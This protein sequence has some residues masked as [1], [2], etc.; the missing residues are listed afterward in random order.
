MTKPDADQDAADLDVA[1][2]DVAEVLDQ[3]VHQPFRGAWSAAAERLSSA[4]IEPLRTG[5]ARHEELTSTLGLDGPAPEEWLDRSERLLEY[6]RSIVSSVL[7]PMIAAFNTEAPPSVIAGALTDAL[8]NSVAACGALPASATFPWRDGAL[9]ARPSDSARRRAGKFLARGVSAARRPGRD[10]SVPLRAVAL[11]HLD[12]EVVNGVDT[13]T[14]AALTAWVEWTRRFEIAWID[15]GDAS[16]SALVK[17]ELPAAEDSD[18]LWETVRDAS[19]GLRTELEALIAEAP[20][21]PTSGLDHLL[22][23]RGVLDAEAAVAG[24]FLLNPKT[25]TRSPTL[26]RVSRM[27]PGCEAWDEGVSARMKMLVALLA[28]LAGATAAQRRVVTRFREECLGR[29]P[30][31]PEIAKGLDALANGLT[32]EPVSDLRASLGSL[33]ASVR[34]ALEPAIAAVPSAQVVDS[35]VTEGAETTVEALLSMVRQAP[36]T[37]GL[38][39]EHDRPPSGGRQS[40][41]RPLALQELARQ[42]FDALRIERIRSSTQGLIPAVDEVRVDVSE[43]PEVFAFA[44]TAALGELEEGLAARGNSRSVTSGG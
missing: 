5:L 20:I 33:E 40:E 27:R 32:T 1:D 13:T 11:R 28:L 3:A 36:A 34:S 42:S 6:R 37:L 38:N 22:R 10:R 15:W 19:R 44:Y 16:L 12:R 24:S 23:A 29:V 31:L 8:E 17:A 18:V 41:K 30:E 39:V 9:S 2:L 7:E 43:L 35:T 14:V 25:R 4:L 26:R 21:D